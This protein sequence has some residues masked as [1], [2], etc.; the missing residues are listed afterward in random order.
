MSASIDRAGLKYSLAPDAQ[1]AYGH[2]L[3][4]S[5]ELSPVAATETRCHPKPKIFTVL[6]ISLPTAV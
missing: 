2:F 3:N 5:A 4:T 6:R 1:I